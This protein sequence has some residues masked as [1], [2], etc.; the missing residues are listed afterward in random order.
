MEDNDGIITTEEEIE[1][2]NIV[3]AILREIIDVKRVTMRDTKSY[4]GILLDDNNRKPLCRLH[5]NSSKK[6]IGIF[7]QKKEQRLEI[8]SVDEI[9]KYAEQIKSAVV[10]YDSGYIPPEIKHEFHVDERNMM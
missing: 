6:Y 5:F 3:K 7:S 8:G 1:G 2:F 10:E 4:C 9:F